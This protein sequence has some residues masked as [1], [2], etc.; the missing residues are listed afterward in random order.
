MGGIEKVNYLRDKG[1]V[2]KPKKRTSK[3][4]FK[5]IK[6]NILF[7]LAVEDD[8]GWESHSKLLLLDIVK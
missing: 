6:E 2:S 4:F 1:S 8:V 3:L 5:S 7:L